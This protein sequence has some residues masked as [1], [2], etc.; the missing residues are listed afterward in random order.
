MRGLTPLRRCDSLNIIAKGSAKGSGPE[1]KIVSRAIFNYNKIAAIL[2]IVVTSTMRKKANRAEKKKILLELEAELE[3]IEEK[4]QDASGDGNRQAK[5]DLMRTRNAYQNAIRRIKYGMGAE[6]R[7]GMKDAE[8]LRST[9][10]Y[11]G[12]RG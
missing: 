3:M 1:R 7:Q 8:R 9:S 2:L 12:Y 5:Y 4:I 11:N 6:E 10:N